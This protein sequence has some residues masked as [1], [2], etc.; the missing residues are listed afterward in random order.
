MR[1]Q[2]TEI[3]K[4]YIRKNQQQIRWNR[5]TNQHLENKAAKIYQTEQQKG[6]N[7]LKTWDLWGHIKCDNICITGVPEGE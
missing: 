6:N 5:G 7:I 3:K 1:I 4:K 2:K